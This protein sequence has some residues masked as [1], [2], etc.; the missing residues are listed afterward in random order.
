MVHTPFHLEQTTMNPPS[1]TSRRALVLGASGGIGGKVARLLRD[2]GW[3]VIAL[4]RA[5]PV[6]TEQRDGITWLRGDAVNGKD[7]LDAAD[8]CQVIVHAVNPPGY[9][10]W[11]EKV[12]PMGKC[13][14]CDPRRLSQRQ[15]CALDADRGGFALAVDSGGPRQLPQTHLAFQVEQQQ[16]SPSAERTIL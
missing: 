5:L 13:F 16:R 11:A 3:Q 9:L 6:H 14:D 10:Q 8:G 1:P 12:L 15:A 7:V 4:K 2:E